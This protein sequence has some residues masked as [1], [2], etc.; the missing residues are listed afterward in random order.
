M[1]YFDLILYLFLFFVDESVKTHP[2]CRQE[3]NTL[4]LW[5]TSE[6]PIWEKKLMI[7]MLMSPKIEQIFST[8]SQ[9][10]IANKKWPN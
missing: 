7:C 8:C 4:M 2:T 6:S 10:V 3:N 5:S 9:D 1:H